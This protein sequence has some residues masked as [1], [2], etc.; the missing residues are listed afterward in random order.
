MTTARWLLA[1]AIVVAP[2][3]VAAHSAA[4]FSTQRL[5]Q[6]DKELS[7]DAF[8][9]RGPATA[10]EPTVIQ[11]IADQLKASGVQTGGEIVNGQR[12]R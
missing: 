7:S 1:P 3:P 4:A 10:I 12:T 8:K 5:S 9:G 11:Y 6:V 2:V